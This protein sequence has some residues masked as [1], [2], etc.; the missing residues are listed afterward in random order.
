M[1]PSPPGR[2]QCNARCSHKG[3]ASTELQSLLFSLDQREFA[4]G[5]VIFL[6]SLILKTL[7]RICLFGMYTQVIAGSCTKVIGK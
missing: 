2:A 7:V 5:T 1:A 6:N 3:L 4:N